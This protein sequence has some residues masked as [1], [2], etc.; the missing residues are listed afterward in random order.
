MVNPKILSAPLT[1]FALDN[2][3]QH[4]VGHVNEQGKIE[5]GH[6]LVTRQEKTGQIVFNFMPLLA[7]LPTSVGEIDIPASKTMYTL[8]LKEDNPEHMH[9]IKSYRSNLSSIVGISGPQSPIIGARS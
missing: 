6:F 5:E 3:M 9:L 4:I 7:V 1:L 2:G 8:E